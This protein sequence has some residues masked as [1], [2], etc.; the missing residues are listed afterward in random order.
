MANQVK[1][2]Y[3]PGCKWL[4]RATWV[5]QELLTTFEKELESVA[6]AP[7]KVSG[8]FNIWVNGQ[9]LFS[10]KENGGF[11]DIAPLKRMLRDQIAPEKSLGHTDNKK[12][13]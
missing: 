6:I 11:I 1:I 10:R 9:L 12:E 8:D 7:A 3:C 2:E 4:P 13:Q 5:A